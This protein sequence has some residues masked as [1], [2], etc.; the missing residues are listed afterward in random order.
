MRSLGEASCN[1]VLISAHYPVYFSLVTCKQCNY[2]ASYDGT[3]LPTNKNS[4]TMFCE[5]EVVVKIRAKERWGV[6]NCF[7][8][9]KNKTKQNT[10]LHD[11]NLDD[12]KGE[13]NWIEEL[14]W[15]DLNRR[16]DSC[17]LISTCIY[18]C[19]GMRV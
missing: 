1:F 3:T 14:N 16:I 18:A 17:P 11:F 6:L 13:L 12:W 5:G 2:L 9:L 4:V 15:I 10:Y 8:E 19:H 7:V